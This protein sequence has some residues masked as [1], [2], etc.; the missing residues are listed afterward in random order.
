MGGKDWEVHLLGVELVGLN[1]EVV[2]MVEKDGF[3]LEM[4]EKVW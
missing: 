1:F 3:E 2:G 4:V